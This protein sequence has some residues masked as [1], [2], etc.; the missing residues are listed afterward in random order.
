V[1]IVIKKHCCVAW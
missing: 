1:L